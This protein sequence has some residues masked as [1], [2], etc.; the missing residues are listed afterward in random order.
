M[1]INSNNIQWYTSQNQKLKPYISIFLKKNKFYLRNR[2][3]KKINKI[4]NK[5]FDFVK[6]GLDKNQKKLILKPIFNRK[7]NNKGYIN[8]INQDRSIVNKEITEIL[9][10]KYEKINKIT[11]NKIF[12]IEAKIIKN[13][14]EDYLIIGLLD[15]ILN[16]NRDRI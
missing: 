3:Q 9:K 11:K 7:E 2:L 12:R 8:K 13:N 15:N 14:K 6:A 4:I 16:D 10:N 1:N 5:N